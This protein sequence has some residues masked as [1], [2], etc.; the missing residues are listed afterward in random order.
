M[1]CFGNNCILTVCFVN[2]ID[3]MITIEMQHS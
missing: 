2:V 1:P 3:C